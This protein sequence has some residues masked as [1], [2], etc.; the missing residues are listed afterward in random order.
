MILSRSP[1]ET[2]KIGRAIARKAMPQDIICLYGQL[3]SGKT[4]LVK[5]MARGVGADESSVTSSSFVLMRQ[6]RSKRLPL[7]HFDL[8]RLQEARHIASLGFEEYFYGE[9][10]TVIEWAERLG[11]L[12]PQNYL[13]VEISPGKEER[14]RKF[15]LT[16]I[17]ARYKKM[18]EE[19]LEDI[20]H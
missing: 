6:Y 9:G 5:G 13:K 18:A 7:F 17:G 1:S 19:I 16:G 15:R 8:Y 12:T 14:E 4:V 3:G 10:V 2:K 20:G 11:V